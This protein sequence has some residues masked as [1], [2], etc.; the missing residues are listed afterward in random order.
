MGVAVAAALLLAIL[1]HWEQTRLILRS[2]S[3]NPLRSVL[4]GLATFVLVLVVTLVW[5]VLAFLDRQTEEKSQ[6][7]KA[8]VMDR[9]QLP[10]RMPMSYA[11]NLGRGAP[12]Q[13]GDYEVNPA[14]DA[15]FWGFYGGMFDP[16]K[17]AREDMVFFFAMEP[18]KAMAIDEHGNFTTMLENL[19][20]VT[21]AQRRQ[22]AADAIEMEKYPYKC[23][24][25]RNAWAQINKRVGERF[26]ITSLNY[27]DINL[28]LG[29]PGSAPRRPLRAEPP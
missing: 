14:K 5:S 29:N 23:C 15:M 18:R 2:L 16:A 20:D 26:K 28:D 17:T 1:L 7:L 4:T 21:D 24:W 6:N 3:R 19:D 27:K 13:K 8:L 11:A 10:S 25:A 12:R 9:Y 22:L